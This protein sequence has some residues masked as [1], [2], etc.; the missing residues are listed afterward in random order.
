[1]KKI[2]TGGIAEN[3]RTLARIDSSPEKI[4]GSIAL[5]TFIG[6]LPITGFQN[7]TTILL[8]F[9]LRLNKIGSIL[10]LEMYSNPVT[11]PF[12]CYADFRIGCFLLGRHPGFVSWADFR[13]L[14]WKIVSEIVGIIFTGGLFLGI[15]V[16]GAAY[17]IALKAITARRIKTTPR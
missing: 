1:M 14:N 13:N 12:I 9:V 5:G 16:A 17:L 8:S 11:L 4:A 6:S 7:L 15:A 2:F 3:I 10:S